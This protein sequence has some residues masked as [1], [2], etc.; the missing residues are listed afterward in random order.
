MSKVCS[1]CHAEKTLDAFSIRKKDS[2][3]GR[4]GELTAK[5]TDCMKKENA[6]K[7][8][9]RKLPE[10]ACETAVQDHANES[11]LD[12]IS[13][14]AFLATLSAAKDGPMDIKAH[15][16]ALEAGPLEA[17]EKAR[18]CGI[19]ELLEKHLLWHWT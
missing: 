9:K 11:M 17:G 5:C 3:G 2:D 7:H 14:P 19:A 8:K 10:E 18:A 1:E 16:S 6:R 15:V 12:V 4:K 13:M